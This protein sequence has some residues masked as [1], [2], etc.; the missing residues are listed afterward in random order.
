MK[1]EANTLITRKIFIDYYWFNLTKIR[2]YRVFVPL[3][4]SLIHI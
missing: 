1:L 3:F 4:L 2:Q